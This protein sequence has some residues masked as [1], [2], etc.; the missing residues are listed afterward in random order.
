[1]LYGSSKGVGDKVR[2]NVD[3]KLSIGEDGL[4]LHDDQGRAISGDIKN[5]WAGVSTL[6][7][8]FVLEHNAI[9]DALKV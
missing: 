8:L 5:S 4:L 2:T 3:G 1:M 7:A 9:C 6:Q